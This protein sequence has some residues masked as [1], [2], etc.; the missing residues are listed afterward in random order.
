[1]PES[2]SARRAGS[3]APLGGACHDQGVPTRVLIV[4]DNAAFRAAARLLLERAGFVVVA[5]APDA[6][7]GVAE[8][9]RLLPDLALVDVGLPDLDGFE[10]AER[11]AA[12][13]G[14]PQVI[15]TSSH[16]SAD[17]GELIARSP[18]RGFI[19]KAELSAR[20]IAALL[21]ASD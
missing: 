13:A 11:L 17:F 15:L 1:M 16:D 9:A 14:A 19:A 20:G 12:I 4:D 6:R 3:S 7:S 21:A 18:A 10:V 8:A 5:E 2:A